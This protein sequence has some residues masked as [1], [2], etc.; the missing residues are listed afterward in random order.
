M[1]KTI[2]I[3]NLFMKI[4]F[5]LNLYFFISINS[6]LIIP[7]KYYPLY[8]YNYTNPTEVMQTIVSSKL[9]AIIEVGS[10]KQKIEIP[11]DFVANEFFISD[12]PKSEFEKTNLFSN[13]KFYSKEESN[14]F[15]SNDDMGYD[16]DKFDYSELCKESFY[17]NNSKYELDFY[18][19]I[20]FKEIES[21]GIGLLLESLYTSYTTDPGK[22]FFKQIKAKKF[23]DNYIW[24]IFFNTKNIEK[25]SEGFLLLGSLPH[26]LGTDLGYYD[27]KDFQ[28]EIKYVYAEITGTNGINKFKVDEVTVYEGNNKK[29]ILNDYP[30]DDINMKIFELNYHS[31]GIQAPFILF[32]KYKE[33]FLNNSN[34]ECNMSEFYYIQ[35]KYFFYCKN[36]KNVINKIKSIL[37]GYN[38]L[39]RDLVYNFTLDVD[40][41]F[42]EKDDKIYCLLYFNN[43]KYLDKTWVM[44]KPFL[45]KYQFSFNIESKQFSFYSQEIEKDTNYSKG[46]GKVKVNI[47]I[48]VII[49]TILL[50][51]VACFL[52]FKFYLY[53][54]FIRKRRANELDDD[55]D[56]IEKSEV[57]NNNLND[58]NTNG[59]IN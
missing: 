17:F 48:I 21:G 55:F 32:E 25:E 41:L 36:N 57:N 51:S 38:F 9:Y 18:L 58:P 20:S 6:H 3:Q 10:P 24:S 2:K 53:D 52:L 16:G 39:S 54:I 26:E 47:L 37:P 1:R 31:N 40:D 22:S 19:P 5:I 28:K 29:K 4:L 7:L 34:G 42:L 56:Y 14:S 50:V 13:L 27:K 35:K 8:K 43:D 44:G 46:G 11:L 23:I 12:E 33:I 49:G 59:E 15:I 45:R 30:I